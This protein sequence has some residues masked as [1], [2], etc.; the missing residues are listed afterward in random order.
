[1]SAKPYNS[2]IFF[3]PKGKGLG[4]DG[5]RM[6][7]L[8]H[9]LRNRYIEH[10]ELRS[11]ATRAARALA[12]FVIP[13]VIWHA[14][15]RPAEALF[16]S[17][18]AMNLSLPDLRG[19]YRMRLGILATMTLVAAGSALLGVLGAQSA[20]G[21][22]LAMGA[23]ALLGGVWRH[24]SADYGP[25]MAVSSALLFLLGLSQMGGGAEGW[26][27]AGLA[28]LGGAFA[29][30]LQACGW[31]IRP[32]HALRYSVAETWVAASDLLAAMR[33]EMQP[34]PTFQSAAVG[35]REGEL[36]A[37]LDRT[38]V[39]LG[40]AKNP[41]QAALVTH[42]EA[43]RREVVHFAMRAV[44][45]N[46]SLEAMAERADFARCAPAADSVLKALSDAA[47]SAA[48]TLIM[49]RTENLQASVVR[50]RRCQH[51]IQAL[52]GQMP[53]AAGGDTAAAQVR[54]AL[55]Q[56]E[57]E[58]PRIEKVLEETADHAGVR[59]GMAASLPDLSALSI[60]SL[61]AWMRPAAQADPVLIRHAV[62]MAVFTMLAVA[63]YKGGDIPRGYWIALTIVVVLQPDYGSTRQ[64][65]AARIGGTTAGILLA[66]VILWLHPGTVL[67]DGLAAAA[68][69]GFAYHLRR[70]YGTAIFLITINL[71][72]ITEA[73]A[74]VGKDFMAGRLFS[75]LLGDALALLAARVFWPVW[76]GEKFA[77]LLAAAVRA[78]QT[79][80]LALGS[81][82]GEPTTPAPPAPDVLMAKRRAENANRYVAASL[83]RLLREPA[84]HQ[85]NAERASALA[86]YNQRV[87]RALTV[88]AVQRPA[89]GNTLLPPQLVQET[90]EVLEKLARVIETEAD[91]TLTTEF[92]TA[93]GK[94]EANFANARVAPEKEPPSE[95]TAASL[96]WVQLGKT[97]T[98]IRA[99]AWALNPPPAGERRSPA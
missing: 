59:R 39:I 67:L 58:L 75:T 11:D 38:F 2:F 97:F 66:G 15:N 91:A 99:M 44:A 88:L 71:V 19:A 3:L 10:L 81:G 60:Q 45:L 64:R 52:A 68:A 87:T 54:S 79:F 12:A 55:E 84:S 29:T 37:T 94:L 51:L 1:M 74:P 49:H 18:T 20:V 69:F 14:L 4:E 85:E 31:L 57:Q 62:R 36:R 86:V 27:L 41:R 13:L 90:G 56:M 35:R 5:G 40:A 33:P 46:A 98:E 83:E 8:T 24:L 50:L 53:E 95:I 48:I 65:A 23:V 43:V 30:L 28:A 92:T 70:N 26:Q 93:L 82:R 21:A 72:L 34:R 63:V 22:V 47:R 42:L 32:Q 96:A 9:W 76:E 16:I 73:Q 6:G 61:G 78:N 80:L 89:A 77:A 25:S 17:T 7:Q